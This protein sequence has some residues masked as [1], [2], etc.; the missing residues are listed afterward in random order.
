MTISLRIATKTLLVRHCERLVNNAC[1][2]NVSS[3]MW[4][5]ILYFNEVTCMHVKPDVRS[6][7][8]AHTH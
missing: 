6:T 5:V 3:I 1:Y 2:S 7:E 8:R 4:R